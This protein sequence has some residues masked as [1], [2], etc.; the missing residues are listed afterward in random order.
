MQC[1]TITFNDN[2]G[3]SATAY[4]VDCNGVART[5]FISLNESYSTTGQDGSASGLPVT[6]GA[7]L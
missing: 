7:F 5:R 3:F 1:R 2:Q 4:W 6:Y